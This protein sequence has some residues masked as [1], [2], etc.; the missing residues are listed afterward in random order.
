MNFRYSF[1]GLTRALQFETYHG[2]GDP[3]THGYDGPMHISAGTHRLQTSED[4]FIEAAKKNGYPEVDDLADMKTVNGVTRGQRYIHP[5]GQRQ[6]TAHQY[7]HPRLRD[8]KHPNLHVL[9]ESQVSR[10][11]VENG[12]A[13]GVVFRPNPQ[14]HSEDSKTERTVRARK[15]VVVSCGTLGTPLVLERSGIGIPDVL[16]KA[17][18]TLVAENQGVGVGFQDHQMMAYPFKTN[19]PHAST[20][21]G[22]VFG[23]TDPKDWIRDSDPLL[24]SNGQ[25]I[26]AKYRPTLE[27]AEALGPDFLDSFRQHYVDRPDKPLITMSLV[28]A[29]VNPVKNLVPERPRGAL[30]AA[31]EQN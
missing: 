20:I 15:Q 31:M 21:N 1:G 18:V 26:G 8:G 24:G 25:D 3:E 10:V 27:E 11:V 12:R 23:T 14:F 30:V 29:Y 5:D 16:S 22:L 7:I 2:K 6:D 4:D 13:T 28:N 19:L 17:G 9:V